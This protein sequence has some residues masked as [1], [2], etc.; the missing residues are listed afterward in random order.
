[1]KETIFQ[2]ACCFSEVAWVPEKDFIFAAQQEW[3]PGLGIV[4]ISLIRATSSAADSVCAVTAASA[5]AQC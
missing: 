5:G 3:S 4:C 2:A 1:M